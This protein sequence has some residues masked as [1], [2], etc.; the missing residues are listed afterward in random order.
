MSFTM[1]WFTCK[2]IVRP[3]VSSIQC[4]EE[5]KK[6]IQ[7]ATAVADTSVRNSSEY[8]TVV[9]TYSFLPQW[10]KHRIVSKKAYDQFVGE[11]VFKSDFS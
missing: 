1:E 10:M 9:S 7:E 8:T 6:N 2:C 11:V 4:T 5:G 3:P